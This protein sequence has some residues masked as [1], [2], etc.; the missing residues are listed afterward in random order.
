MGQVAGAVAQHDLGFIVVGF[1][2]FLDPELP[3]ARAVGIGEQQHFVFG[4]AGY[5]WRAD[6]FSRDQFGFLRVPPR[7]AI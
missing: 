4:F 6:I 5:R 3:L 1:C 7:R 2:I